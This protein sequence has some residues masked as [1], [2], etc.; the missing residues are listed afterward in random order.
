MV[1][2]MLILLRYHY[3]TPE[4]QMRKLADY[5]FMLRDYKFAYSIYDTVKKDFSS[6]KEWKYTAGA[7][8]NICIRIMYME[9]N[10]VILLLIIILSFFFKKKEMIGICLL[11]ALTKISSRIDIDNYF[12]QAVNSYLNFV[13]I[14]FYATRSTLLYFELLKY[15]GLYKNAP[16][17]LVR[18]AGEVKYQKID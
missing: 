14:P 15:R 10:K 2:M 12:E 16:S 8:V 6:D 4:A 5:A 9:I 11:I 18:M 1:M 3:N 17:A 13:K 7:Q